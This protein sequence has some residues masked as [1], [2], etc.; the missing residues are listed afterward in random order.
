MKLKKIAALLLTAACVM[1]TA[2][3]CIESS[4]PE[5]TL[6]T[7]AGKLEGTWKPTGFWAPSLGK[8][9]SKLTIDL[10][11]NGDVEVDMNQVW[12]NR[13]WRDDD[14]ASITSFERNGTESGY[15]YYKGAFVYH[16][17]V[18]EYNSTIYTNK[19]MD[20]VTLSTLQY[21]K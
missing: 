17:G 12:I 18:V 5:E 16:Q 6:E 20:R 9:S 10:T 15:F 8:P 2:T 11:S 19:A 13:A 14:D 3:G 21:K 4:L 7:A 1:G